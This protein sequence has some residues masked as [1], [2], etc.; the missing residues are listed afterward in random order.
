MIVDDNMIFQEFH[1]T[2]LKEYV[3]SQYFINQH[4]LS[5][6]RHTFLAKYSKWRRQNNLPFTN[7]SISQ[8]LQWMEKH[9][10]FP[11]DSEVY[12]TLPL[13]N[14]ALFQPLTVAATIYITLYPTLLNAVLQD[15]GLNIVSYNNCQKYMN[16]KGIKF[17]PHIY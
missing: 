6:K 17:H 1:D 12:N 5:I 3:P 7:L 14:D 8:Y 2:R 15:C 11:I 16:N 13:T 10:K 9:Y 4:H